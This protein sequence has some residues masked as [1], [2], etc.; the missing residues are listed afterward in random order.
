[1]ENQEGVDMSTDT[2]S[3]KNL[4]TIVTELIIIEN[5]TFHLFLFITQS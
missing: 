4:N 2:S 5:E 3:N 1:M